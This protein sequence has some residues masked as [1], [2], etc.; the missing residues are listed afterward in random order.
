MIIMKKFLLL[1]T[2]ILCFEILSDL[3]PQ[4]SHAAFDS[5]LEY[6]TRTHYDGF[7]D[8]LIKIVEDIYTCFWSNLIL[9]YGQL[10]QTCIPRLITQEGSYEDDCNGSADNE[11]FI[12][13]QGVTTVI[14]IAMLIATV[15]LSY[16]PVIGNLAWIWVG[17]PVINIIVTCLG[18]YVIAP[19]EYVNHLLGYM[20]CED[21]NGIVTN[22]HPKAITEVDVPFFYKCL[23]NPV[24][25]DL[26]INDPRLD[27]EYGNMTGPSTPYCQP[28]NDKYAV[29]QL[30]QNDLG[31]TNDELIS[32][33][34]VKKVGFWKIIKF[35]HRDICD[36]A[37]DRT[38][39]FTRQNVKDGKEDSNW[40]TTIAFYRLY[41]GKIQ[42]CSATSTMVAP[43]MNGCTFIAPPIENF[44]IEAAYTDNTRCSYFLSSRDD[45]ISLGIAITKPH[46]DA[47]DFPPVGLFLQSDLH[48]LSTT[49]G[50]LQDLLAKIVV[51]SDGGV[52][53]SFLYQIQVTMRNIAKVVLILYISLL[54][55]KIISNPQPPQ[56]GEVV[57]YIL[58]FGFVVVMSGLLGPKIWYDDNTNNNK[59]LYN[60]LI[61]SMD[62]LS[63]R[64]LQ[65]T[66]TVSPVN[67]CYLDENGKNLLSENEIPVDKYGSTI[68]ATHSIRAKKD[69]V[70]LTVWDY[71]DCKLIGYLNL[72]S[73]KYTVSGLI[74]FWF[75]STCILFPSTFLLGLISVIFCVVL[76]KTMSKFVH[77]VV[78]SLFTLTILVLVSPIMVCFIL[79]D[80][81]KQTFD[82]WFKMIIGY[83]LYPGLILSFVA[84]MITTFDAV[85]Y[86]TVSNTS[87]LNTSSCSVHDICYKDTTLNND[88]I[89]CAIASTIYKG[90][91]ES[92]LKDIK[93]V[94]PTL[95]NV[96]SSKMFDA[97]NDGGYDV[98]GT[99][100]KIPTWDMFMLL[101]KS[102][103]KMTLFV[104]LF[105]HIADAVVSFLE[106]LLALHG[107]SSAAAKGEEAGKMVFK[108][109]SMAAS[110]A[111]TGSTAAAKLASKGI[112]KGVEAA[113]GRR[114]GP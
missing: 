75:V 46:R 68:Q 13:D 22:K 94:D 109:A 52:E 28:G 72:N 90:K 39:L 113:S 97:I 102:M 63:N 27:T 91:T 87:C 50:C 2:C 58:K 84:L 70:K 9:N 92:E 17:I 33:I 112:K 36:L 66:N 5:V 71:I 108:A 78:L 7:F 104:L 25:K 45:L 1:L 44:K 106:T 12:K 73:C 77:L 100:Y 98:L 55:I 35:E 32:S 6:E 43:I 88:S 19:Y 49:L 114:G 3:N 34:I 86:G 67:M 48:I 60:L 74:S 105:H 40:P 65:S 30:P 64:V 62:D 110:V 85:F 26:V 76:F 69:H 31:I 18:S 15:A 56:M 82:T 89:Y 24:P 93:T 21:D 16:I 41:G 10:K 59:G 23:D 4:Q 54:G 81:T 103:L 11:S 80:Y 61:D 29:N 20:Q 83:V 8:F 99:H 51:S 101:F 42:L 38:V 79:F 96:P 57:V 107:L 47:G 53:E 95:C 37:G 111:F 14:F